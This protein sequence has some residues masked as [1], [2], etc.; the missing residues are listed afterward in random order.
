LELLRPFFPPRDARCENKINYYIARR[1][2]RGRSRGSKLA[3]VARTRAARSS[4]TKLAH[5]ARAAVVR[6][7]S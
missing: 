2:S 1:R 7:I 4:G 3:P 6:G 5:Q